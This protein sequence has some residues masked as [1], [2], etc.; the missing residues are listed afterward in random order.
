MSI[1]L[2]GL[3]VALRAV[4][5]ATNHVYGVFPPFGFDR[6]RKRD[7]AI[8]VKGSKAALLR[9]LVAAKGGES[10]GIGVPGFVPKWR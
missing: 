1:R 3:G 10:A 6:Q 5:S 8:Y 2:V 4:L 9:T 7:D